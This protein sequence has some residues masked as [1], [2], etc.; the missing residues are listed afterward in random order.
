VG[1]ATLDHIQIREGGLNWLSV[2]DAM[3]KGLRSTC[4]LRPF[5]DVASGVWVRGNHPLRLSEKIGKGERNMTN[6]K[7]C[8]Y[9][10]KPPALRGTKADKEYHLKQVHK[11]IWEAIERGLEHESIDSIKPDQILAEIKVT[12]WSR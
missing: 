5:Q 2:A 7:H 6:T 3:A 8:Q 9:C 10:R 12:K 11:E 4:F 1:R